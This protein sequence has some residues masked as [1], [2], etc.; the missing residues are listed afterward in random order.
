MSKRKA[1]S[2]STITKVVK[3]SKKTQKT[4]KTA[5]DKSDI[6]IYARSFAREL[7]AEFEEN[8]S[9]LQDDDDDELEDFESNVALIRSSEP[10]HTE[11]ELEVSKESF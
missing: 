6:M 3:K 5:D 7:C 2:G 4:Q 10:S 1:G 11:L 9:P 8:G